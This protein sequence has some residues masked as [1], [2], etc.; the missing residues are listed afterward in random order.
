MILTDFA[1]ISVKSGWAITKGLTI[2]GHVTR[3]SIETWIGF[4]YTYKNDRK[5][6]KK[7]TVDFF[8]I[9]LK[10]LSTIQLK[11]L[12]LSQCIPK[13]PGGQ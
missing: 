9:K 1:V 5:R 13:K 6:V 4:T 12:L 11:V 7:C 8:C 10:Y 2:M 3:A